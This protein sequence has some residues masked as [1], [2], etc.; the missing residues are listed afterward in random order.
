MSWKSNDVAD[1]DAD[2]DADT[3]TGA[4]TDADADARW[5]KIDRAAGE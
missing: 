2:T 5:I 4:E 3:R 1:T